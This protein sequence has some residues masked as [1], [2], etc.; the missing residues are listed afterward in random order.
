MSITAPPGVFDIIPNAA[1]AW[2]SSHLWNY[3]EGIIRELAS[4]YGFH[5]I[6]T[7]IFERVELFSRGVGE[8]TDIVSKEMYTF[9]DRGG[10]IMALRPEGTAAVMR[11]FIEHQLNQKSPLHK[12][13]YIAP[14]FRY[15]RAQA[16]RYRQHHQFGVESIGYASPYVDVEA[17]D[18]LWSLYKKLGLKNIT[19]HINS[20]GD[21]ASRAHFREALVDYLSTHRQD[22]SKDS[23]NRLIVNPLRILDSKDAKDQEI[24][25]AA[26]KLFDH[27]DDASRVY[28]ENVCGLLKDCQIPYQIS[29]KLVRGLDYYNGVVFEITS[30]AL[31]SQNSIGGG[32]RYDGLLKQVGGPDLPGIGF[33]S[34]LERIIQ[35]LL[36]QETAPPALQPPAIFLIP[37]GEEAQK[38]CFKL[39][40][41]LRNNSIKAEMDFSQRKLNKV[42]QYANQIGAKSITV[43]G[44]NE[45]QKGQIQLK[46]MATGERV[47]INLSQIVS[48]LQNK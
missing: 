33:G 46:D 8:S 28:F 21:T 41:D 35:T 9:E 23:Q 26:P 42:M 20:L 47:E 29:P 13:F 45:L 5:E 3:V 7:P 37:L 18:L 38:T 16:G 34:G 31:G 39:L 44:E 1:E 24:L 22:L 14:M 25:I 30:G 19:L 17:I 27:L 6:R 32:G 11:A 43:I 15:E 4:I 40:N 10:R 36:A 12:L 48:F 2:Q